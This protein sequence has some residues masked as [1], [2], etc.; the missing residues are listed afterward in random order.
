MRIYFNLI[1][2]LAV[3]I[4]GN[5]LAGWEVIRAGEG[6]IRAVEDKIRADQYF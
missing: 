6:K 5:T 3:S 2:T 1:R 4:W